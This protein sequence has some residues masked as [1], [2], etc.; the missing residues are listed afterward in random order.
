MSCYSVTD[1]WPGLLGAPHCLLPS[2]ITVTVGC[3]RSNNSFKQP[4]CSWHFYHIKEWEEFCHT[5]ADL[6]P[7]GVGGAFQVTP[8]WMCTWVLQTS[9][10]SVSSRWRNLCFSPSMDRCLWVMGCGNS[11]APPGASEKGYVSVVRSLVAFSKKARGDDDDEPRKEKQR[12]LWFKNPQPASGV[13]QPTDRDGG[14]R[15]KVAKYKDK[16][17][18][19]VTAR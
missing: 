10:H 12:G 5:P 18:P 3:K 15:D 9:S 14:H 7:A 1:V 2:T 6:Q 19:R 16:F 13:H 11:K 8:A 4:L 17:D